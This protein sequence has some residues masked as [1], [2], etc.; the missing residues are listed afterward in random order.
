MTSAYKR[1]ADESEEEYI[2]RICSLKES[3]GTWQQVTGVINEEL[4]YD[5]NE[6][7]YRKSF[8]AYN[9]IFESVN[10]NNDIS[11]QLQELKKEK[12]KV[13]DENLKYN[14]MLR[15]QSRMESE[16]ELLIEAVDR[17]E[18]PSV[19][20]IQIIP[21]GFK[22]GV[23]VFGDAHLGSEIK[24]YGLNGDILNEYNEEVFYQRMWTLRDNIIDICKKEELTSITILDLGDSINGLLRISALQSIKY[25]AVDSAIL[26]AKFVSEWIGSISNEVYVKYKAIT[27]NHEETRPFSSKNGDFPHENLGRFVN[28]Y[29]KAYLKDNC[30]VSF[31]DTINYKA[32]YTNVAGYNIMATH[33]EEKNKQNV[34]M[35][36]ENV[37]GVSI[38]YFISG[39]LHHGQNKEIGFDKEYIGVGSVIGVDDYSLKLKKVS[40]PSAKFLVL[41]PNKGKIEYTIK[42][43]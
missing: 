29:I 11:T 40:N 22:E 17:I 2:Y 8:Q 31:D 24:I 7:K 16:I 1:I 6:S 43:K 26:Y 34:I 36:Y 15:E 41:E 14:N 30:N 21:N 12:Q 33:G 37:Y 28:E 38:N 32:I 20:S 42:L 23:A 19:P 4:N 3:I 27:G 13:R 35:E 10:K 18:K 5:Y 25:G 39:H 9:K